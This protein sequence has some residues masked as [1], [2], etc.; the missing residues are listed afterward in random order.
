MIRLFV[1][2]ILTWSLLTHA[3]PGDP[4]VITII[5][6]IEKTNRGPLDPFQ[7]ALLARYSK[8]F[9]G[10]YALSRSDLMSL[11]QHSVRARYPSWKTDHTFSGPR[12]ADVLAAAGSRG[13]SVQIYGLDGYRIAYERTVLEEAEYILALTMDDKPLGMGGFGPTYVMV[14]DQSKEAF[15]DGKP[16]DDALVWGAILIDV[17]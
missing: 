13:G 17:N 14:S 5:G 1:A 7:D 11:S 3:E 9:E 6:A 16:S 4:T 2:L 12:L 15:P 8:G 10:A